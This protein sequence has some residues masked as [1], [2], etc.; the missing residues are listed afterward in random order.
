VEYLD[1]KMREIRDGGKAQAMAR[2]V[3]GSI[4]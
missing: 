2:S 1:A 4:P 3:H